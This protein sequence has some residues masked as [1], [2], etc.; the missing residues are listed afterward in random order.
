MHGRS[1]ESE[2]VA[3]TS[4]VGR[5]GPVAGLPC[6]MQWRRAPHAPT[7]GWWLGACIGGSGGG[8]L[9]R[10][11]A[12]QAPAHSRAPCKPLSAAA[13]C[14]AAG[15][16]RTAAHAREQMR[17]WRRR[18]RARSR[19]TLRCH[20][21]QG[22]RP[23]AA[24]R[25]GHNRIRPGAAGHRG[26]GGSSHRNAHQR[27]AQNKPCTRQGSVPWCGSRRKRAM[28]ISGLSW[29]WIEDLSEWSGSAIAAPFTRHGRLAAGPT[30]KGVWAYG[31]AGGGHALPLQHHQLPTPLPPPARKQ[32][33]WAGDGGWHPAP[34]LRSA[35]SHG[36][37]PAPVR[38]QADRPPH[39][40]R[41]RTSTQ[42]RKPALPRT[43]ADRSSPCVVHCSLLGCV[44]RIRLLPARAHRMSSTG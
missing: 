18:K 22:S 5:K 42:A 27:R 11:A 33:A 43:G 1:R 26:P 36:G 31:R 10:G 3:G 23:R 8:A 9:R 32:A 7:P 41:H 19:A 40:H 6:H 4:L 12:A 39:P 13:G 44:A 14:L 29:S 15:A 28:R 17:V 25:T 2:S 35:K 24:A 20:A 30:A 34:A 38:Q 37:I 16:A 21:P